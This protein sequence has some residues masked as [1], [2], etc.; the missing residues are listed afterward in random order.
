MNYESLTG[1]ENESFP[2]DYYEHIK[3]AR[4]INRELLEGTISKH[5][6][7]VG[8]FP[9]HRLRSYTNGDHECLY[10]HLPGINTIPTVLGLLYHH[11]KPATVKFSRPWRIFTTPSLTAA[12]MT[13]QKLNYKVCADIGTSRMIT[14]ITCAVLDTDLGPNF[15]CRG[16]IP[17]TDV[18]IK[19]RD[20][21]FISDS[22]GRAINIVG[23]KTLIV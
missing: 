20:N 14:I 9:G 17:S 19:S 8:T 18:H 2:A 7:R 3:T 15:L 13:M 21:P 11:K 4:S 6:R 16:H 12:V 23:T 1:S 22:N 10:T 5:I